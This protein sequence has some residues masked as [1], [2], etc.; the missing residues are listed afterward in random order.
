MG[1]PSLARDR[2][3]AAQRA[4]G[5]LQP[6]G[7]GQTARAPKRP[8]AATARQRASWSQRS[9]ERAAMGRGPPP[10]ARAVAP[11]RARP[12]AAQSAAV[13]PAWAASPQGQRRT[14]P[15]ARLA[16]AHP[17]CHRLAV[18]GGPL[19]CLRRSLRARAARRWGLSGS[20][21]TVRWSVRRSRRMHRSRSHRGGPCRAT[22]Q[23]E[24]RR[25]QGRR[26]GE[27]RPAHPR[28]SRA[29]LPPGTRRPR[30]GAARGEPEAP[31]RSRRCP[32]SPGAG[33]SA[34]G[35]AHA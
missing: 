2:R 20:R 21:S 23:G 13:G 30:R 1:T 18:P 10:A 4:T 9:T 32:W 22:F 26:P 31:P 3:R 17:G 24:T 16:V 14:A 8:A 28:C 33:P 5:G 7:M 12:V 27:P 29:G 15:W 34:P 19:R 6:A 11:G 25:L 35:A